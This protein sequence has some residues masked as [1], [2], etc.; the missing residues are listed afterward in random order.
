MYPRRCPL[1]SI[2]MTAQDWKG[3]AGLKDRK[4]MT[5]FIAKLPFLKSRKDQ[6]R[7]AYTIT[8]G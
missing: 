5:Y 4:Y 6:L 1:R 8:G 7:H 2:S 3:V